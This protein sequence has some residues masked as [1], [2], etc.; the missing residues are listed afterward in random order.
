M[1]GRKNL[2]KEKALIQTFSVIFR[3]KFSITCTDEDALWSL[4]HACGGFYRFP[5]FG[6]FDDTFIR[7]HNFSQT[8]GYYNSACPMETLCK[9]RD[10]PVLGAPSQA[11][12]EASVVG[13]PGAP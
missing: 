7:I 12:V 1:R 8:V 9:T 4:F 6:N 3:K 10:V 11:S 13:P 5:M 2:A